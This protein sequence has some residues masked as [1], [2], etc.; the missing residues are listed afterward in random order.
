MKKIIISTVLLMLSTMAFSQSIEGTWTTTLKSEN[1][2]YTF[3]A[4]LKVKGDTLTGR[5]YSIDGSVNIYDGKI[6]N[7]EFSYN[8]D[9]NYNKITHEGKLVDGD[10]QMKSSSAN[11]EMEF[12]MTR[13]EDE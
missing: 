5:L 4:E 8:F 13:V 3:Y 10:L 12:V 2:S 1:G 7:N 11:G 6:E 9:L